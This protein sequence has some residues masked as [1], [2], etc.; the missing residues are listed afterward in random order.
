MTADTSATAP[1]SAPAV[2][3]DAGPDEPP[4]EPVTPPAE[5]VTPPA[6]PAVT[7]AAAGV[8]ATADEGPLPDTEA[9]VP[10]IGP[11]QRWVDSSP[12]RTLALMIGGAAII[13]V[14]GFGG[15]YWM[16][17]GTT[18]LLQLPQIPPEPWAIV[19]LVAGFALTSAAF[20]R[21]HWRQPMAFFFAATGFQV[22]WTLVFQIREP[23]V[24][25]GAWVFVWFALYYV[26]QRIST[27][28]AWICLGVNL[29]VHT[30][31]MAA[32]HSHA[33]D[34]QGPA[35]EYLLL[36][37]LGLNVAAG[38]FA[39][40]RGTRRRFI[41]TLLE[42]NR[43]LRAQR[44]QRAELAVAAERNRI[45][46]EMHDI[47]SHSL[48]VMVTL[49]DGAARLVTTEP[50]AAARAMEEISK[51]GRHAVG[52]MR[53][54]IAFLRSEADLRP[55]PSLTDLG[56]LVA[57]FRQ[58]GLPVVIELTTALPDD[59]AFG[60]TVY[61]IVQEALTNV[62]RHAP[63]APEVAVRITQSEPGVVDIVVENAPGASPVEG[64]GAGAGSG[65]GLIG[66]RQR[67]AVWHGTLDAGPR[68]DGGWRLH[69]TLRVDDEAE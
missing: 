61:R 67:V 46:R 37:A 25:I 29:A 64:A 65:Q 62:L 2:T 33:W 40:L 32:F 42:R 43:L 16:Y 60:L 52:D 58:S 57:S 49:S 3:P 22:L 59:A 17:F 35:W 34:D 39:V 8:T 24:G 36:L 30:C 11:V 44:D 10:R 41:D 27:L 14:F 19:L 1:D 69:V 4:I 5:P 18:G 54:L 13:A 28:L 51:T 68:A 20:A 21:W 50:E 38:S 45:A 66:L 31:L 7:P 56:D 63:A 6:E 47:V 9:R 12:R 26:C 55:Q 53:R 15:V 23:V 48:A